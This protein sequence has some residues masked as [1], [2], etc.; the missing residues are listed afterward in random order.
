MSIKCQ[1]NC[2]K[3]ILLLQ[4]FEQFINFIQTEIEGIIQQKKEEKGQLR[5][6]Y[7]G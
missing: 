1:L 5:E 4:Y 6:S 3:D 7:V 2:T